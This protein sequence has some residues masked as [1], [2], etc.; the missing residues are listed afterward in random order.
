MSNDAYSKQTQPNTFLK[1]IYIK[2]I[3]GSVVAGAL[4]LKAERLEF[5]SIWVDGI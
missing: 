5:K 1:T 4:A 2:R 3:L